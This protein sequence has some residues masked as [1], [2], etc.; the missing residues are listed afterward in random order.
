MLLSTHA[1]RSAVAH[2]G[3][4]RAATCYP[5]L[6]DKR[7]QPIGSPGIQRTASPSFEELAAEQSVTP[8]DDFETL[9]G[10]P[11]PEDESAEEFAALLREWRLEG[12]RSAGSR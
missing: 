11:A 5:G 7:A 8:I 2:T 10:A 4:P 12:T 3:K 9:L 1:Q 6:V